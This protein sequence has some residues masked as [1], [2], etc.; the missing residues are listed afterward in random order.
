MVTLNST[1][2]FNRGRLKITTPTPKRVGQSQ[3]KKLEKKCK[4]QGPKERPRK[5]RMSLIPMKNEPEL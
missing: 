4:I 5:G 1:P 3:G 2:S